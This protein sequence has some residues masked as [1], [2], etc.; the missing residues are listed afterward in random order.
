MTAGL[1]GHKQQAQGHVIHYGPTLSPRNTQ[2]TT[3]PV[4]PS[5]TCGCRLLLLPRDLLLQLAQAGVGSLF[6]SP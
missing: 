5:T 1:P 3:S 6:L 2:I 4:I